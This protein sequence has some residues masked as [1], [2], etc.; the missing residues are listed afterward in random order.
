MPGFYSEAAGFLLVDSVDTTL[1]VSP[2]ANFVMSK[3]PG[4][5]PVAEVMALP[6]AVKVRVNPRWSAEAGPRSRSKARN[7]RV[8]D[9]AL[10]KRFVVARM[11]RFLDS[12][13]F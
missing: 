9:S 7:F 6:S 4:V 2:S 12:A 13:S 10:A 8:S 11:R 1:W 5:M 3:S